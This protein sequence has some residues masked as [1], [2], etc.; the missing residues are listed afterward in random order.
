MKYN[1][2]RGYLLVTPCYFFGKEIDII[3]KKALSFLLIIEKK[4]LA[5]KMFLHSEEKCGMILV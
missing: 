5:Y 3:D 2:Y 1:P 4:I